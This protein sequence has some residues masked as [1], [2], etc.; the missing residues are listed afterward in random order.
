MYFIFNTCTK[1]EKRHTRW[2]NDEE[3]VLIYKTYSFW[4]Y[5]VKENVL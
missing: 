2:K 4:K 1:D 5:K 3:V